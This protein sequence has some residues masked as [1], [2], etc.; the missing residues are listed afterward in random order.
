MLEDFF[1]RQCPSY[2]QEAAVDQLQALL[3]NF[4]IDTYAII[5]ASLQRVINNRPVV[6]VGL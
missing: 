4:P 5:D 6:D 1:D 2:L 3:A